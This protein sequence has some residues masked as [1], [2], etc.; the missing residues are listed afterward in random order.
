MTLA[1]YERCSEEKTR[2][3]I[4]EFITIDVLTIMKLILMQNR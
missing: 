2:T 1:D 4:L 3:F